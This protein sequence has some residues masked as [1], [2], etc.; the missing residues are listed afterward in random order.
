M[1]AARLL[2]ALVPVVLLVIGVVGVVWVRRQERRDPSSYPRAR[3]VERPAETVKRD[4]RF[5]R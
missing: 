3:R 4:A 1:S 2:G 5:R